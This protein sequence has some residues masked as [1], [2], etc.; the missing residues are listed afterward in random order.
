MTPFSDIETP[1][2]I[3]GA[4]PG[5]AAF[6]PSRSWRKFRASISTYVRPSAAERSDPQSAT[7]T[8]GV[9]QPVVPMA[10]RI[11]GGDIGSSHIRVP[12][13]RETAFEIAAS[14]GTM[15]VSPT[16]RTP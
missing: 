1:R 15:G 11:R 8:T 12:M 9:P 16:P 3:C 2:S 14:G 7:L 13:A 6:R 10:F 4:R 5:W